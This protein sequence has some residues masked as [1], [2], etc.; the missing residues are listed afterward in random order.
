MP[1]ASGVGAAVE[2]EFDKIADALRRDVVSGVFNALE[3]PKRRRLDRLLGRGRN[4][5]S[6]RLSELGAAH[7]GF[8]SRLSR[9]AS[10]GIAARVLVFGA[11]SG[12]LSGGVGR[13]GAEGRAAI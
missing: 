9:N 2:N 12:G 3:I 5:N 13:A 4:D 10:G 7:Y 11:G 6:R 1:I 8:S